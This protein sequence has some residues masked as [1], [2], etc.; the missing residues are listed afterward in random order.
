MIYYAILQFQATGPAVTGEWTEKEPASRTYR[1]WV[2]L[3]GSHPSAII[4]LIEE[5]NGRRHTI[6][7]WTKSHGEVEATPDID[8]GPE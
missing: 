5:R 2:G 1:E 3:Y 7:T 6:K 4:R 8:S